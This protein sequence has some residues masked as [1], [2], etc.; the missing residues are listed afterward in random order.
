V[1]CKVFPG[2]A[3]Q[4]MCAKHPVGQTL[5]IQRQE[6]LTPSLIFVSSNPCTL[7]GIVVSLPEKDRK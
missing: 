4:G 1:E 5:E 3:R 6:S 7:A 2:T